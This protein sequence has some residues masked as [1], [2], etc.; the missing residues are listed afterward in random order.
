MN[1]VVVVQLLKRAIIIQLR[2]I[3]LF[4][5]NV[6]QGVRRTAFEREL[7]EKVHVVEVSATIDRVDDRWLTKSLNS[8]FTWGSATNETH[9]VDQLRLNAKNTLDDVR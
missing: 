1:E 2:N 8:I 5:C 6:T 9:L 3:Q 7:L 4:S